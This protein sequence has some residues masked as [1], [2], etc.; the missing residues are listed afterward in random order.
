MVVAETSKG[1]SDRAVFKRPIA[2]CNHRFVLNWLGN[3]SSIVRHEYMSAS[4]F[5][6]LGKYTYC[7]T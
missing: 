7:L 2:N 3:K 5:L 4:P 6:V 1:R